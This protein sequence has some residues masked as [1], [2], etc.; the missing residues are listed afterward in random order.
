MFIREVKDKVKEIFGIVEAKERKKEKIRNREVW[1]QNVL[2]SF[3]FPSTSLFPPS[4]ALLLGA[5][6]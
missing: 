1:C 6:L 3:C 4:P 5:D 2:D